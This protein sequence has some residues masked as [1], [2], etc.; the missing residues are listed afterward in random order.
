MQQILYTEK[1]NQTLVEL[2]HSVSAGRKKGGVGVLPCMWDH[3]ETREGWP[4][5]TVET[6][7]NGGSKSTYKRGPY[8]VG[9]LGSSCR[10]NRL[11]SCLG[12]SIWPGTK[13]YFPH[14]TLFVPNTQH[15]I[16]R[17]S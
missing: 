10:Y 12:C 15:T 1:D 3:R 7:A 6:E 13:Y 16:G 11:L 2:D 17:Q 4:L 14:Y 9:A 8:L 5:L